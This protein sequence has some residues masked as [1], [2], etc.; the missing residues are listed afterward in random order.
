VCLWCDGAILCAPLVAAVYGFV[1]SLSACAGSML[2]GMV[3]V[4]VLVALF[5]CWFGDSVRIA[6]STMVFSLVGIAALVVSVASLGV[7]A[8]GR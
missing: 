5:A 4:A 1:G 8:N 7:V 3:G 6:S 2:V